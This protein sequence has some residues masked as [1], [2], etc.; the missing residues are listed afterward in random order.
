[1]RNIKT[2]DGEFIRKFAQKL[3]S[4]Y[5]KSMKVFHCVYELIRNMHFFSVSPKPSLMMIMNLPSFDSVSVAVDMFRLNSG[6]IATSSNS[7]DPLI[8]WYFCTCTV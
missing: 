2:Y 3:I 4:N 6:S 1:M 7:L 5:K 8:G